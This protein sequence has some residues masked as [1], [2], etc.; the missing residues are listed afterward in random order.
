MNSLEFIE[1]IIKNIET[2]LAEDKRVYQLYLSKNNIDKNKILKNLDENIKHREQ[3]L[4]TLQQI[5]TELETLEILKDRLVDYQ[6]M[7]LQKRWYDG[8][9]EWHY[10]LVFDENFEIEL[11][12]EYQYETIKRGMRR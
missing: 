11:V 12:D 9:E 10:F 5:K 8:E 6:G 4:Q 1:K 3:E 2:A 7:T